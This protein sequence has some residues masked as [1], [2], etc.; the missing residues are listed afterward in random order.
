MMSA[1]YTLWHKHML[2]FV[3]NG[4][5][6]FGLLLQPIIL[7]VLFGIGM[8]SMIGSALP[9]VGDYM[10]FIAPGIITVTVLTGAIS[11]GATLLDERLRGIL[12]EYVVAPI[13]RLSIL[14][15]NALSTVTKAMVQAVIVTLIG[16]L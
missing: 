9:G 13:P 2:K 1:T 4:E 3:R 10:V 8:R 6:T 5:E 7:I 14:A 15:A 12:K 16:V 11:G